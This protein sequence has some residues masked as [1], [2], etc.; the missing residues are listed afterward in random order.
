MTSPVANNF[1]FLLSYSIFNASISNSSAYISE[2]IK[3]KF[4]IKKLSSHLS[5]EFEDIV[6]ANSELKK[7]YVKTEKIY[8]T[9]EVSSAT[10]PSPSAPPTKDLPINAK[11]KKSITTH[12]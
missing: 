10:I 2:L 6:D 5:D 1:S 9:P 12:I 3:N 7:I 11:I 8:R 4:I